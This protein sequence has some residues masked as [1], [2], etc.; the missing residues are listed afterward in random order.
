M[1]MFSRL[2]R[3]SVD[4]KNALSDIESNPDGDKIPL[5]PCDKH[6]KR[7]KETLNLR[8]LI[9]KSQNYTLDDKHKDDYYKHGN[10]DF[11]EGDLDGT[12]E[13]M[14]GQSM[15]PSVSSL[16]KSQFYGS[17]TK[18]EFGEFADGFNNGHD[19]AIRTPNKD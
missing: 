19:R 6:I 10:P 2:S 11:D 7:K 9:E 1:S 17:P 5:K 16:K 12:T 15:R 14:A 8:E 13:R 3:S 4:K 18:E